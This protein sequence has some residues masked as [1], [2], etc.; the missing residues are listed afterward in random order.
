MRS[1]E[2]AV[3]YV[4]VGLFPYPDLILSLETY[5]RGF[6]SSD[7]SQSSLVFPKREILTLNLSSLGYYRAE[8]SRYI[9]ERSRRDRG[10]GVKGT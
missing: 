9:F 6:Y 5:L 8:R 4:S 3:C 7:V 1:E 10:R 2:A